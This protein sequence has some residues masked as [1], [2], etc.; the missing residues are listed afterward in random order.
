MGKY[1][2]PNASKEQFIFCHGYGCTEQTYAWFTPEQWEVV[3]NVFKTDSTNAEEERQKIAQAIV[4]METYAGY[5]TKT[6]NDLPKAPIR[7]Q[8]DYELDC[9]DET[10]NST[11][12]LTFLQEDGLLKFHKVGR[13][14]YRGMVFDGMYPHNTATIIE[15]E[16]KERFV[17]DT[18]VFAHATTPDIRPLKSWQ[19]T[20]VEDL[21]K[22]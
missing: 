19:R 4:K 14:A 17:V 11:K 16:T 3:R 8:S 21:P 6:D 9:I 10:V 2:D 15:E 1:P 5:L 18:Y 20:R 13:P 12:Y 7:K 22:N